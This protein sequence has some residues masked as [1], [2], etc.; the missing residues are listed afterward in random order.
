METVLFLLSD[1]PWNLELLGSMNLATWA[2][3]CQFAFMFEVMN[4]CVYAPR[5]FSSLGSSLSYNQ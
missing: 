2:T 3:E 4:M 5:L 1:Y